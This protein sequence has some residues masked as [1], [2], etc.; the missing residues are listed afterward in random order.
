[1]RKVLKNMLYKL[2]FTILILIIVIC[3]F[4]SDNYAAQPIKVGIVELEYWGEEDI[5]TGEMT[6]IYPSIFEELSKRLDLELVPY[7]APY[8]RIMQGMKMGKYDMTITLPNDDDSLIV[9]QKVW[10]IR[11]GVLSKRHTPID[12]LEQLYD[13]RVGVIRGAKFEENFDTDITINKLESIEHKNL[14]QML[15]NDR[16]AAIASDL[17]I[18]NGLI[19]QSG[20]TRDDYAKQLVVN[21]LSLHLIF[22]P[23]SYNP[24][25]SKKITK[26]IS[27]M[28]EDETIEKI[29]HQYIK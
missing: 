11:L 20:K 21:E 12:S 17:S 1:M 16:I 19:E 7:L 18:L 23:K 25:L 26:T 28:I 3:C 10:T 6:G 5:K 24:E 15:D 29:I 22:S 2:I 13:L 4:L 27:Q 8:P 14:L 9:G